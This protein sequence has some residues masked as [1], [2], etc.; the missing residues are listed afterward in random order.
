MV[1]AKI[2]NTLFPRK[3]E[4]NR[5][6]LKSKSARFLVKLPLGIDAICC[7]DVCDNALKQQ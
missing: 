7:N 6:D 3:R 1:F 5:D 4:F 2:H